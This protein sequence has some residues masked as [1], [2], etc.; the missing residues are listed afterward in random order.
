M[1]INLT[2][3]IFDTTPVRVTGV[4]DDGYRSNI[5]EAILLHWDDICEV[6]G[7]PER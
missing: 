2:Q 6:I 7:D 5:P 3:K 4:G 1:D